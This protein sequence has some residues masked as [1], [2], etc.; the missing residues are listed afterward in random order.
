M[1]MRGRSFGT[2]QDVAS[3]SWLTSLPSRFGYLK[4]GQSHPWISIKCSSGLLSRYNLDSLIVDIFSVEWSFYLLMLY[5]FY[6]SSLITFLS[7]DTKLKVSYPVFTLRV[8]PES[9][10]E[11]IRAIVN[12]KRN[13]RFWTRMVCG[14]TRIGRSVFTMPAASVGFFLMVVIIPKWGL[15]NGFSSYLCNDFGKLS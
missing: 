4:L 5:S 3:K 13:S 15:Y 14:S 8:W 10:R 9:S 12:R 11:F 6:L 2:Q 1:G 7:S